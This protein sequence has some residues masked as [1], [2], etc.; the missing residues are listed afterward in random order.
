[1]RI[2]G[3]RDWQAPCYW[4]A[5]ECTDALIIGG[6]P[7]GLA[8]AIGARLKGLDVTVMDAW[9]PP[10]DKAC[11]EGILPGGVEVLRRLGVPITDDDAFPFCGIRFLDDGAAV[12][13]GFSRGPGLAIR[14]TRLHQLLANRASET[15]VRLLWNTPFTNLSQLPA[16]R[17]V[18]GADGQNSRVRHASGLD[19]TRREFSRFGFRRHYRMSPWTNFV[20]VHWGARCQ[21]YVTPVSPDE[22]GVALL[23]RDSHLRLDTALTEFPGLQRRLRG[24]EPASTERGASTPTRRLRSVFRGHT[25]LVGDASGSVDAITG[26]GLSLAFHQAVAL[27]EALVSGDLPAYQATHSHLARR[28]GLIGDLLLVFDRFPTLRRSLLRLLAL[29]PPIFAKLVAQHVQER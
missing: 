10:I 1:L 26:E 11:G 5:V 22:I 28:P 29:D 17:W 14:R 21:I 25:L 18:V 13:A 23:T 4:C 20:E 8:T 12:E 16:H 9:F 19:A 24:I 6:G 3:N 15:G 2:D 7:A 27:S